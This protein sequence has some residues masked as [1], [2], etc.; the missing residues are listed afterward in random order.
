[1]IEIY[2]YCMKNRIQKILKE[3]IDIKDV[4]DFDYHER[5]NLPYH[6]GYREDKE[7]EEYKEDFKGI[8]GQYIDGNEITLYRV[9]LLDKEENL[10]EP[11]G[12]YWSVDKETAQYID[13]EEYEHTTPVENKKPYMI[14]GRFRLSDIDW[15]D[16]FDLYLMNDFMEKEIRVKK[17][18]KPIEYRLEKL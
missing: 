11:L 5:Q 18:I 16:S 6:S 13:D 3:F 8:M 14:V 10:L 4:D 12:I 9:V 7:Q 15:E 17:G 2:L 1:M